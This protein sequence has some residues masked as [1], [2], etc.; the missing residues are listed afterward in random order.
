VTG[1]PVIQRDGVVD[2][3]GIE[4]EDISPGYAR[5]S[6]TVVATMLNIYGT[7][8]G[9]VIFTLADS[10][11]GYAS[12]A[13]GPVAVATGGDV[14]FLRPARLGDRLVAE[15]RQKHRTRRTALFEIEVRN[16]ATT[17]LVATLTGRIGYPQ[18]SPRMPSE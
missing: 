3:L 10:A 13:E 2:G 9:G 4:I 18:L 12:N 5:T 11:L 15:A 7:C 16:T 14:N 17:E 8:H 6:T 1:R